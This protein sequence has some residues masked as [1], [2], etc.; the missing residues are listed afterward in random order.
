M[1]YNNIYLEAKLFVRSKALYI[2]LILLAILIF[3]GMNQSFNFLNDYKQTLDQ[4][5]ATITNSTKAINFIKNT[6]YGISKKNAFSYSLLIIY[7]ILP[8]LFSV[9]SAQFIGLEFSN[10][11]SRIKS[12]HIGWKETITSKIIVVFFSIVCFE[13]LLTFVGIIV[14]NIFWIQNNNSLSN[15]NKLFISNLSQPIILQVSCLLLGTFFYSLISIIFTLLTKNQ[16]FGAIV[17]ILLPFL[18][19]YIDKLLFNSN[20]WWIPKN[21]YGII[22]SNNFIFFNGSLVGIAP[23]KDAAKYNNLMSFFLLSLWCFICVLLAYKIS[24]KQSL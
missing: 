15:I 20:L 8:L 4:S 23:I 2:G 16:L 17:G 21:L 24:K 7:S 10:R 22:V 12:I 5:N 1:N 13:L 3:V 6:V 11:T 19:D 14:N 9:I 18:E